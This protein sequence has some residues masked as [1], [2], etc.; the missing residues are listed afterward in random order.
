MQTQYKYC[1]SKSVVGANIIYH[2]C[3]CVCWCYADARAAKNVLK[4]RPKHT[5]TERNANS[6]QIVRTRIS[7]V[8]THTLIAWSTCTRAFKHE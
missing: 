1:L 2:I 5:H 6:K 3:V 7:L 8:V 4:A